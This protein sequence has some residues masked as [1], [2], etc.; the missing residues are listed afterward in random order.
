MSTH[1]RRLLSLN[2]RQIPLLA[3]FIV[4][5][6]LPQTPVLAPQNSWAEVEPG[7]DNGSKSQAEPIQVLLVQN[8]SFG[9][10]SSH[11]FG[12]Q[13]SVIESFPA[14]ITAYSSSVWETDDTPFITASGKTVGDGVVA[15]NI[16]PFGT[17]IRI[18]ELFGSKIFVV[19]DRMS[20]RADDYQIDVWFP[21]SQSAKEFGK[22]YTYV[23]TLR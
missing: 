4:L 17:K 5:F 6:F 3:A 13:E 23:E 19:E 8:D 15:S 2:N 7:S 18:P 14:F 16:L 22:Q 10:S 20:Q 12:R 21:S 1:K 11:Y 9:A